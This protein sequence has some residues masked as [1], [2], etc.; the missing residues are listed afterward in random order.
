MVKP[1]RTFFLLNNGHRG[2]RPESGLFPTSFQPQMHVSF[3]GQLRELEKEWNGEK[4]YNA[5]ECLAE[6]ASQEGS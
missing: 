5:L 2:P 4:A 6:P 3:I 1:I